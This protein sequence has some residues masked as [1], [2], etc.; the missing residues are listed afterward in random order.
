MEAKL[1]DLEG[2]MNS[3][4]PTLADGM[5]DLHADNAIRKALALFVSILHLRHPKRLTEIEAIHS[6]LVAACESFPKDDAGRPLI[7]SVEHKGIV[8]PFDNSRW[9]D[10]R[11]AG[12]NEK[13]RMFVDAIRQN[14]IL[15]AEILMNKRWYVVFSQQPVF[16]TTDNPVA[17]VNPKRKVF[18][19]ATRGTEVFFPL[20]PTRVLIMD[21]RHDQ[22]KG[23]YYP[24]LDDICCC[25]LFN[26]V[27]WQHSERFM[28][29]PRH[30]DAVCAELLAWSEGYAPDSNS[31]SIM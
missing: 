24:L 18:G 11:A 8:R 23:L 1:A 29:S 15:G 3:V 2:L 27:A 9:H 22:P 14:A 6:Q 16:I 5:V 30:T 7:E 26:L 21:D 19:L 10:Y 17:V 13:K 25:G 4:W 28:I 12:P 20:S 31:H